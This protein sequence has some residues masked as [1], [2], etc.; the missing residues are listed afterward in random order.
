MKRAGFTMIELIF[1]IVILGILAAVAIP[2]LAA[3]RED[4]A[5]TA[6]LATWK[7]AISQVQADTTASGS[8]PDFT[9]IVDGSDNLTVTTSVITATDGGLGGNAPVTCATAT[10]T[11]ATGDLVIAV[12]ST[13]AG[14]ALFANVSAST[15]TLL[16]SGIIR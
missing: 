1:V 11:A 4:A 13:T 16:G 8:V 6:A 12:P 14:C 9:T 7:T 15:I 10:Y 5:A 2:K 3:T